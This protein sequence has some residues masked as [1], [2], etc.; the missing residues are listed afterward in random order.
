MGTDCSLPHEEPLEGP[1]PRAILSCKGASM[2][3][4]FI[5]SIQSHYSCWRVLFDINT[6]Y[7]LYI[8]TLA[9]ISRL[10]LSLTATHC[11]LLLH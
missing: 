7:S 3:E 6:H 9:S 1:L 11:T 10:S 8:P 2:S 4:Y 5:H